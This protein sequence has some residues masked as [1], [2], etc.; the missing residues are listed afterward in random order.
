MHVVKVKKNA[1]N[2]CKLLSLSNMHCAFFRGAKTTELAKT[3]FTIIFCYIVKTFLL[4]C[5]KFL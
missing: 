5:L 3:C 2:Y 1:C 4:N